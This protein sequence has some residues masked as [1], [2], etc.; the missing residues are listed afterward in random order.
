MMVW[1]VMW[2]GG[3]GRTLWLVGKI[4]VLSSRGERIYQCGEGEEK[5]MIWGRWSGVL[6]F[7]WEW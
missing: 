6:L 5:S 2:E 4:G 1:D 3:E 7:D